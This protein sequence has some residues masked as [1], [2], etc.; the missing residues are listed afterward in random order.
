MPFLFKKSAIPEVLV[1]ESKEFSDNRGSFSELFK[2]SEFSAAGIPPF[3][4]DNYSRSKKGVIR[5]LH[6]QLAPK[7]QGKL[8][9]VLRGEVLDVAVDVRPGSTTFLKHVAVRLSEANNLML[10][11]PPGFAHGFSALADDV[12]F[13][14]KCTEE[15]SPEHERGIRHD[16]PALGID[17]E[18][19]APVVSRRDAELP[20]A[21]AAELA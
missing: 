9:R 3:V 12:I 1:V 6:Y 2:A 13:V 21:S 4:Q 15:Y 8:V 11:I 10:Y 18:V 19:D 14:Y 5:G 17:W 16:D 20:L 7:A